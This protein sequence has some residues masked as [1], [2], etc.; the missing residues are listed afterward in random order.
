MVA[1]LLSTTSS[2]DGTPLLDVREDARPSLVQAR[3]RAQGRRFEERPGR[4][5]AF[6]EDRACPQYLDA[7][8][9]GRRPEV[10][11]IYRTADFPG[12]P[13]LEPPPTLGI[14]L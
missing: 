12:D 2:T 8:D 1:A 5:M 4:G 14:E 6:V 11:Q 13:L 10:H 7:H 3:V 9:G